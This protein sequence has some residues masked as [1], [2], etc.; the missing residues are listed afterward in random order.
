MGV[1]QPAVQQLKQWEMLS[2]STCLTLI[3]GRSALPFV[4][5]PGKQA[6]A[7]VD[8]NPDSID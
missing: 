7:G 3:G 1:A 8:L 4:G 2:A 5:R 6:S